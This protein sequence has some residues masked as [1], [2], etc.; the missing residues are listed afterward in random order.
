MT[1]RIDWERDGVERRAT[2]A[3]AWTH[4]LVLV[5]VSDPRNLLTAAWIRLEHVARR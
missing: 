4:S 5:D 3:T 2:V 1:A